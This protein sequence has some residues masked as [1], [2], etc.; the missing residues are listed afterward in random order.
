MK[1]WGAILGFCLGIFSGTASAQSLPHAIVFEPCFV[2]LEFEESKRVQFDEILISLSRLKAEKNSLNSKPAKLTQERRCQMLNA[3]VPVWEPTE[4]EV[5]ERYQQVAQTYVS[6]EFQVAEELVLT[7]EEAELFRASKNLPTNRDFHLR[8][9]SQ[10]SDPAWVP[11]L[12][13]NGESEF[14]IYFTDSHWMLSRCAAH[15]QAKRQ[16]YLS[17]RADV[18]AL[19]IEQRRLFEANKLMNSIISAIDEKESSKP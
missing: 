13:E 18:A 3:L 17:V 9:I 4:D 6:D 2:P 11:N 15:Q 7:N 5:F 10:H 8:K 16:M 1:N 14:V 12:N 19:L